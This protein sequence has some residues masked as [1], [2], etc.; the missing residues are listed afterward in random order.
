MQVRVD[1]LISRSAGGL[2]LFQVQGSRGLIIEGRMLKLRAHAVTPLTDPEVWKVPGV[3]PVAWFVTFALRVPFA[4]GFPVGLANDLP[5]LVQST[6]EPFL[7]T[8]CREL[9]RVNQELVE[10]KRANCS[11]DVLHEHRSPNRHGNDLPKAP[12]LQI[13]GLKVVPR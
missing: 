1:S 4:E 12:S 2:H 7:W 3:F 6:L 8:T 5:V 11:P 10:E 13:Q 9:V